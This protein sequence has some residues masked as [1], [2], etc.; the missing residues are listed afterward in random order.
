MAMQSDLQDLEN[1]VLLEM[2][3]QDLACLKTQL[4]QGQSS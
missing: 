1:K 4:D 2:S 3:Q